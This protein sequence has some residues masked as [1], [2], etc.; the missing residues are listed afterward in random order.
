[1]VDNPQLRLA[2]DYVQWT[3]ENVFLTGKAGTGKTTF[4]HHLKGRCS[5]RMIVVAPT[6][7]A[8][9]N[10]GGVTIHSFFQ[11][12]F[13][14]MIPSLS[15]V[16]TDS[17]GQAVVKK[18]NRNKINVIRGLDLLVIDEISMVRADL[19]DGI[20]A[21]LR[22]YKDRRRPFGGVQLLMIGDLQ[23]LAPVIK[24][25]DWAILSQYY[26]TGFFFGSRALQ[27]AGYVGIE[28]RHIY[29]QSDAR[30]IDLL[31]RVRENRMDCETCEALNQRYRPEYVPDEGQGVI[32]L[33]THNAQAQRINDAKLAALPGKVKTFKATISSDFPEYLYPTEADLRLKVGAQVMF[34]RNDNSVE[35][36]YY[37]GKIGRLVGYEGDIV[38][39]RCPDDDEVIAVEQVTWENT[40]YALNDQTKEIQEE[41][42]GTFAQVPLKLAWA[43]TIHKSQGLTF[44]RAVIDAQAAFAHGQ[45]YVALSRLRTLE[46][47]VLSTPIAAQAVK[48]HAEVLSFSSDI[49]KGQPGPQQLT[50]AKHEYQQQLLLDL[51]DFEGLHR[52]LARI[53][54]RVGEQ[55]AALPENPVSWFEAMDRSVREHIMDV[56]EKFHTQIKTLSSDPTV[57]LE[58]HE[59]LQQRVQK[60]AV[61]FR[62]KI[63]D[64][65]LEPLQGLVVETDNKAVRKSVEEAID[66]LMG[67][68]ELK[69]TCLAACARGFSVK[70]TL[71]VRAEAAIDTRRRGKRKTNLRQEKDVATAHP[72]LYLLLKAWRRKKAEQEKVAPNTVLALKTL[73]SVANQCPRSQTALR[74]V[75]GIGARTVQR[76][77]ADLLAILTEYRPVKDES[78]EKTKRL[79]KR[80]ASST[81]Q[82]SFDLF[83]AGSTVAEVAAAR[84]LAVSTIETHLAHFVRNGALPLE[85]LISLEKGQAAIDFFMTAD[86]LHLSPAKEHF[87]DVYSYGE[88]K[89]IV[90]H[91]IH[92]GAVQEPSEA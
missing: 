45:V 56:A 44:D 60:G 68:G 34:V 78:A 51:F 38:R 23:Q 28:L 24:K 12:P 19:L 80:D 27:E 14:P 91:L 39:V 81:Q 20:D 66:Q 2:H 1:M 67:Q 25:E 41:V 77:G 26:D 55:A 58:T 22:Q 84:G 74:R 4:L 73:I 62:E 15:G 21:V 6:G 8:A 65:L 43:I 5:K 61:Y 71:K 85:R 49:E 32:T 76:I 75:R 87:G 9:I 82:A 37:N 57:N 59:H 88:L 36:Q 18:F 29:R 31:N 30:F 11:M 92:S 70:T 90:Q 47:L 13:G 52:S 54:K 48:A 64:L 16:P 83:D 35:K 53:I 3:G 63:K 79:V 89:M 86:V 69:R 42:A 46:G 72:E 17:Q 50:Q 40:K 33:T 10:A 7:V